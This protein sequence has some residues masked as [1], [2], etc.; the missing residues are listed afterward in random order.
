MNQKQNKMTENFSQKKTEESSQE[1]FETKKE[2]ENK[3]ETIEKSIQKPE[4]TKNIDLSINFAENDD[5]RSDTLFF[6]NG[7]LN[8]SEMECNLYSHN[9]N[10]K[11]IQNKNFKNGKVNLKKRIKYKGKNYKCF[12]KNKI[13]NNCNNSK[14]NYH[15]FK[16]NELKKFRK[17]FKIS[18][19]KKSNL[20]N[21][22]NNE[23]EENNYKSITVNNI[24]FEK[25]CD[26]FLG[27]KI[28]GDGDYNFNEQEEIFNI[29]F[30]DDDDKNGNNLYFDNF[31]ISENRATDDLYNI[32]ENNWSDK[33]ETCFST[34]NGKKNFNLI[35]LPA[36]FDN[37]FVNYPSI[38]ISEN[39]TL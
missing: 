25:N 17:H 38:E 7:E 14:K 34:D 8:K 21:N 30:A 1:N 5:D 29:N 35:V 37:L 22:I 31:Q 13:H 11:E 36:L 32:E 23:K 4:T 16:K 28:R 3:N 10:L 19:R 2:I 12:S 26:F 9:I 24:K 39:L 33:N 27:K 20:K 15:I 18:E 6:F